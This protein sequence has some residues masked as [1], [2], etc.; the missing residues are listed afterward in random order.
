[1][2]IYSGF[3]HLER[4]I[5][6]SYVSLPEGNYNHDFTIE[7]FHGSLLFKRI[8]CQNFISS[9]R[10][11]ARFYFIVVIVVYYHIPNIT[12]P[13]ANCYYHHYYILLLLYTIVILIIIIYVKL[14]QYYDITILILVLI[15]IYFNH[16]YDCYGIS[17]FAACIYR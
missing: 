9:L 8:P 16:Y 17:L 2:T 14:L 3:S 6:H 11:I 1:M 15:I 10:D 13:S 7:C 12:I 4:V 5:F